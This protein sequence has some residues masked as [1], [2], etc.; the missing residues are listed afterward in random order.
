MLPLLPFLLLLQPPPDVFAAEHELS[1]EIRVPELKAH[2]YRLA[3]PEYAGRKGAGAARAARY[4]EA[5][6]RA[7]KLTPAFGDSYFQTIPSRTADE[8]PGDLGLGR[9]VGAILDGS[10]P[11]LKD[12]WIVLSANCD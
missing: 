12:A 9:N 8:K 10:D 1:E 7:L 3:S 4:V 2:V 6:F 11:V 5:Q